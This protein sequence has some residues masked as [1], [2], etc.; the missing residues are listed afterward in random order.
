MTVVSVSQWKLGGTCAGG[1]RVNICRR[2]NKKHATFVCI[3]HARPWA[4][5]SS[6]FHVPLCIYLSKCTQGPASLVPCNRITKGL[7]QTGMCK[8]AF[9]TGVLLK[10]RKFQPVH[11]GLWQRQMLVT[12]HSRP[13]SMKWILFSA[14]ASLSYKFH[15]DVYLQNCSFKVTALKH[16]R[17]QTKKLP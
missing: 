11:A 17:D 4:R 9:A 6:I 13:A 15:V 2:T 14:C 12:S 10:D 16:R 1:F 8:C 3:L 5:K 7:S